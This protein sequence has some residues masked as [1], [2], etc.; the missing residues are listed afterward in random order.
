LEAAARALEFGMNWREM[1][2]RLAEAESV[3][4]IYLCQGAF[5]NQEDRETMIAETHGVRIIFV[6]EDYFIVGPRRPVGTAII[7]VGWLAM[8]RIHSEDESIEPVS[9]VPDEL[10]EPEEPPKK[11]TQ[12]RKKPQSRKDDSTS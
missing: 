5:G 2:S 12:T 3:V 4:D 1:L 9:F 7:K 10:K 8:I 11:N 6:G